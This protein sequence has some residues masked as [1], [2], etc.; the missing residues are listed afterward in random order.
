MCFFSR[1]KATGSRAK[2]RPKRKAG[3]WL[4]LWVLKVMWNHELRSILNN[5]GRYTSS[6]EGRAAAILRVSTMSIPTFGQSNP[7]VT[8][9]NHCS[10]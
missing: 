7:T 6:G 4:D 5:D 3:I 10:G 8:L 2:S 1:A 9:N